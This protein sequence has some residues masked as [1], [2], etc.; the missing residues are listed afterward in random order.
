MS[1]QVDVTE[2]PANKNRPKARSRR[3]LRHDEAVIQAEVR[4]LARALAPYGVLHRNA[5]KQSAGAEHWHEGTFETALAAG[6]RSGS[7]ERLPAGF[8]R[9]SRDSSSAS[10]D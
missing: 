2:T 9:V 4:R 1:P 3:D 7:L 8:Y 10:D 6:V 5:L